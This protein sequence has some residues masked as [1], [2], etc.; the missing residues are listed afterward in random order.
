MFVFVPGAYQKFAFFG[1]KR[2][3]YSLCQSNNSWENKFCVKF[4][5]CFF[6]MY[7]NLHCKMIGKRPQRK[8]CRKKRGIQ[9]LWIHFRRFFFFDWKTVNCA[10]YKYLK[11]LFFVFSFGS[12]IKVI[13]FFHFSFLLTAEMWNLFLFCFV[14]HSQS[15]LSHS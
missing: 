8:F 11:I 1:W 12:A 9:I 6:C 2:R 10:F 3:E 7:T 15:S 4:G 14:F 5:G 13:F